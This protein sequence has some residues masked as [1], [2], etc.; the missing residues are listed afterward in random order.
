MDAKAW[1]V[2]ALSAQG[3]L[4]RSLDRVRIRWEGVV[5]GEANLK[6][7]GGAALGRRDVR[8]VL[9]ECT[10]WDRRLGAGCARVCLAIG[11]AGL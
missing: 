7:T 2:A 11:K 4:R 1:A 10:M 5:P 8:A 3:V 6:G 9:R